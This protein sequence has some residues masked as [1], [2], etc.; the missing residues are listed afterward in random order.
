[1]AVVPTALP[2][3]TDPTAVPCCAPLASSRSLDADDAVRLAGRLKAVA[4]PVRL[5]L[6]THLL[7]QPGYEACTCDLAPIVGVSDATVSH[8]L[9]TLM[10]AGILDGKRRD[11]MNV[12][13]RLDPGALADLSRILDPALG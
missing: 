1:M 11:G 7:G 10:M 5:R 8:H 3:L 4:D 13:Y 9:K 2:M 12:W 6:V